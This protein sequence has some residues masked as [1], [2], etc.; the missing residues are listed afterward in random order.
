MGEIKFADIAI[1]IVAFINFWGVIYSANKSKGSTSIQKSDPLKKSTRKWKFL[2]WINLA[3]LSIII[4]FLIWNS[5]S[6]P[7]TKIEVTSINESDTV[8]IDEMVKGTY[9]QLPDHHNIWIVVYSHAVD[10]YYPQNE[11]AF[12][13]KREMVITVLFCDCRRHWIQI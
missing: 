7:A 5:F 6:Q 1:I 10:R 8:S 2:F 3:I 13:S 9:R 12:T 11:P 4:I